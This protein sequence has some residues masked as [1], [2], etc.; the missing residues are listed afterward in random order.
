MCLSRQPAFH[1]NTKDGDRRA[2]GQC[3]EQQQSAALKPA[4]AGLRR[5]KRQSFSARLTGRARTGS[6]RRNLPNSSATRLRSHSVW[7]EI[8]Q[9]TSDKSFP[10]PAG[11]SDSAIVA[12][13]APIPRPVAWS[14]RNFQ[15]GKAD[16]H[17]PVHT[18]WPP[19]NKYRFARSVRPAPQRSVLVAYNWVNP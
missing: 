17:S 10:S 7:L 5:H 18:K 16:D 12:A 3:D 13:P 8:S 6:S 14:R 19:T 4:S 2:C 11:R 1:A 15:R 9:D